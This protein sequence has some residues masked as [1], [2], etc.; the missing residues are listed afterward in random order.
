MSFYGKLSIFFLRISLGCIFFYAGIKQILT[1]A[2]SAGGFLDH[3]QTFSSF[4]HW[5]AS[6]SVLPV[7]NAI[8]PWALLLLGVSL[9]L[10]L[11]LRLSS[12][13]GVVLMVLYYFPQLHF[14]YVGTNY[15]LVDEH[16]VFSMAL[17]LLANLR[18][19]RIWGL[20]TWCANLPICARY[21][22]LRKMLG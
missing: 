2:W 17:L 6:P 14:P 11:F 5:L 12:V 18:A 3:A 8:N 9:L 19:G 1:P 7:I 10:G 20:E 16:V 15:Y 21:P 22:V 4:Y 13:L